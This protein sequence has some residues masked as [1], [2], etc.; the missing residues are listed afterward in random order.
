MSPEADTADTADTADSA[1]VACRAVNS[2]YGIYSI[3]CPASDDCL[4]NS[5]RLSQTLQGNDLL[6]FFSVHEVRWHFK[7][8]RGI[9][10]HN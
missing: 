2:K 1:Q 10:K 8:N 5:Y 9:W 3:A 6:C 4:E 7:M